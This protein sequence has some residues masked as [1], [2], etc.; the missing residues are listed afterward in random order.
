[1]YLCT[2]V[3]KR[4]WGSLFF[5]FFGNNDKNMEKILFERWLCYDFQHNFHWR[6]GICC[7]VIRVYLYHTHKTLGPI[8]ER[9]WDTNFP[10]LYWTKTT[11]QW[12]AHRF[13]PKT[14]DN[15]R[16]ISATFVFFAVRNL[17]TEH[18][19]QSDTHH[20]SSSIVLVLL[21]TYTSVSCDEIFT[22]LLE[23]L[24]KTSPLTAICSIAL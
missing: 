19:S 6:L 16:W 12:N 17:I 11:F 15:C 1:M 4:K 2:G 10:L 9:S 21:T 13:L 22:M 5:V 24:L 14:L 20:N 8:S 7:T 23:D 3:V 18:C